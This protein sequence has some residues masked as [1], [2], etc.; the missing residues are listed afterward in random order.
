MT[1]P[2]GAIELDRVASLAHAVERTRQVEF[3]AA[4]VDLGGPGADGLDALENLH[5]AAP[6]LP[7]VIYSGQVDE[8][9][10][11]RAMR[12]GAQD[13][14]LKR[15]VGAERFIRAIHC[16][17]ERH[18]RSRSLQ[19][20]E[21]GLTRLPTR[22][23]FETSLQQALHRARRE[24]RSLALL[25]LVVGLAGQ[26]PGCADLD[27]RRIRGLA[28]R[29]TAILRSSDIVARVG[30]DE[31][32]VLAELARPEDA[33]TVAE[34][35]RTA[36]NRPF[37]LDGQAIP[38]RARLGIALS[39]ADGE[40]ARAL[41]RCAGRALARTAGGDCRFNQPR[42]NAT[43]LDAQEL[44]RALRDG[45][46]RGELQLLYQPQIDLA[47][48][49]IRALEALLRWRH[50]GGCLP[51]SLFL[52]VAEESGLGRTIGE[53]VLHR[54]CAQARDWQT[55]V[56]GGVRVSVNLSRS[57]FLAADVTETVRRSLR[58]TELD[59]GRLELEVKER[60]LTRNSERAVATV[61]RL[62]ALGVGV[63]LDDFAARCI[64]VSQ[65]A[66]LPI[67]GVKLDRSLVRGLPGDPKAA[68]I[69]RGMVALLHGFELHVT[70]K[71]IE[72]PEQ[73]GFVRG[74]T[75]DG[76][77]GFLVG[78]PRPANEVP[79]LLAGRTLD[80]APV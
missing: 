57:Q 22:A 12:S 53:W 8:E 39:P 25:H 24:R 17:I 26:P 70:A 62:R 10:A 43:L 40:S 15:E 3:D 32:M 36:T 75:C 55:G 76:L 77:Q 80:L 28:R 51:P 78:R 4:V 29:L 23:L 65:L 31:F 11:I 72:T 79:S 14:L 20:M 42:H 49:R 66:S 41:L 27:R 74:S 63:S 56:E 21:D 45:V 52:P 7:I 16:A 67:D 37:R 19:R 69:V 47:S 34:K 38:L 50:R 54:A 68:C 46:R 35:V 48:G 60:D 9:L 2:T 18:R 58:E 64:T 6:D 59:P 73:H 61:S 13:Y 30:E 71:G 5:A 33:A 1:G 44:G